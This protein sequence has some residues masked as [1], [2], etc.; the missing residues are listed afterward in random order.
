MA[1]DSAALACSRWPVVAYRM[2]S[3]RWQWAC[4]RRSAQCLSPRQGLLVVGCG[5]RHIGRVGVG[6]DDT[7]LVQRQRLFPTCLLLPGQVERLAR[8]LPG[9]ITAPCQ[10]GRSR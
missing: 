3:L 1:A 5:R 6:M 10:T 8:V 9:L 4:P 7:K 2:P